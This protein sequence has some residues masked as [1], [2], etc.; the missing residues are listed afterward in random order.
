MGVMAMAVLS[1]SLL[2][3][4][5][6]SMALL[7]T[8]AGCRVV[9]ATQ[10][11][12][13]VHA[14]PTTTE[15]A[16]HLAIEVYD[17]NDVAPVFE[18]THALPESIVGPLARVPVVP[19]GGDPSRLFRVVARLV[20]IST[21]GMTTTELVSASA[22]GSYVRNELR[23]IHLWIDDDCAG[24]TC[25]AGQTCQAGVC[26]GDCFEATLERETRSRALCG[27]CQICSGGACAPRE[28]G[29]ACGCPGDTCEAGR[30]RTASAVRGVFAGES[31]TCAE[32][33]G[34]GLFCWGSDAMGQIAGV[35]G[36]VPEPV[37]GGS[38]IRGDGGADHTCYVDDTNVPVCFGSNV[39]GQM[40][41]GTTSSDPEPPTRV[42]GVRL[43]EIGAGIN[44]TCGL[45]ADEGSVLCWGANRNGVLGPDLGAVFASPTRVTPEGERFI[46]VAAG[47]Y[48]ACAVRSDGTVFCWGFGNSGEIGIGV[49]SD[50]ITEPTAVGCDLE[51]CS[52][53]WTSVAA[54]AFHSCAIRAD[55]SM[56]CWGG[57]RN[58]QLG[59]TTMGVN[60][61]TPA[62]AV[63]GGPWD[64]VAAGTSHT[65]ALSGG[66]V[67]CWGRND[68]GQAG[69]GDTDNVPSP[70]EIVVSGGAGF[71]AIALGAEHSCAIRTD[72]TLY[73]WGWDEQHQL[74]L[75]DTSEVIV[76]TPRRVCFPPP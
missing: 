36:E 45:T 42:E 75:G 2:S 63:E 64:Q 34:R 46:S 17:A 62:R 12:V 27:E 60:S 59:V 39:A 4:A 6:L 35:G 24:A 68:H 76:T 25:G 15:A 10:V 8:L 65:C 18:A 69:V 58:G 57:N 37:Q 52:G 16:T 73:C 9:P 28:A 3:M 61:L 51:D 21:D 22:S 43:I 29:V 38:T 13:F 48:H 54:G 50:S 20:A 49:V 71:R 72:E 41:D 74:G 7:S 55:G 19:E 33:P 5:L 66:R 14:A 32:V 11:L 44:F 56:R 67:F 26:V 70:T 40:G 31:H 53:D 30:C 1:M 47:G 23:E